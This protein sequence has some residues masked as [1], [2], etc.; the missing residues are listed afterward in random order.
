MPKPNAVITESSPSSLAEARATLTRLQ[1]EA[2]ELRRVAT[3]T[4]SVETVRREVHG[5]INQQGRAETVEIDAPHTET[6]AISTLERLQATRRLDELALEIARAEEAVEIARMA[7]AVADRQARDALVAEGVAL[8]RRELPELVRRQRQ[9]QREWQAFL[10]RCAAVDQRLG[11]PRFT[12][13]AW[14]FVMAPGAQFDAFV[15]ACRAAYQLDGGLSGMAPERLVAEALTARA[16]REEKNLTALVA[17]DPRG[18]GP[19]GL[20]PGAVSVRVSSPT[21][22][23][24]D[25][26]DQGVEREGFDEEARVGRKGVLG[27]GFPGMPAHKDHLDV[28]PSMLHSLGDLEP[29][30]TRHHDVCEQKVDGARIL[31]HHREGPLGVARGQDPVP[32][33]FQDVLDDLHG[34]FVVYEQHGRAHVPLSG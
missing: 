6:R 5:I 30:V 27:E 14:P 11:L 12:E 19:E 2:V 26:R 25:R 3:G 13:A 22:R 34:Q 9:L 31:V 18:G 10:G 1:T 20:E 8:V 29:A 28:R 15:A 16:V 7:A 23:G 4:T 21:Q 33:P 32:P 17:A 24:A